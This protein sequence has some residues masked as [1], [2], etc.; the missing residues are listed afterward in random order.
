MKPIKPYTVHTYARLNYRDY[1]V[2]DAY[3]SPKWGHPGDHIELQLKAIDHDA[4][5]KAAKASRRLMEQ[6]KREEERK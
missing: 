4:A 2:V 5:I 1:V 3:T 6:R